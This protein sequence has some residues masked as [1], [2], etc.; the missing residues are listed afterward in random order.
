MLVYAI[1]P[2]GLAEKEKNSQII[3]EYRLII[4]WAEAAKKYK[5][6]T[7][8]VVCNSFFKKD[9]KKHLTNTNFSAIIYKHEKA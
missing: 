2:K 5:C 7:L 8:N 1:N 3:L 6:F 4:Y 9:L